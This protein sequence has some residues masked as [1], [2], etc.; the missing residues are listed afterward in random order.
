[1]QIHTCVVCG[2][3]DYEM[4]MLRRHSG[5]KHTECVGIAAKKCHRCYGQGRIYY[6]TPI[7]LGFTYQVKSAT[8]CTYCKGTGNKYGN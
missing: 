7:S 8:T 6:S 2:Q 1:M 3:S 5:W 4:L